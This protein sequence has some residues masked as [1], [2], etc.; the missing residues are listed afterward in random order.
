[1]RNLH[2]I[3][4][5][6]IATICLIT[7]VRVSQSV[8]PPHNDEN[9]VTCASC[10][11]SAG[12]LG[13]SNTKFTNDNL[14][15]SCHVAAGA[16]TGKK[17]AT[18][19][20]S[21]IDNRT[22]TS[23]RWDG[24]MPATDSPNNAYGLRSKASLA[25]NETS[26]KLQD[27]ITKFGGTVS[28]S[29][30]HSIHEQFGDPW[31]DDSAPVSFSTG[32][33]TTTLT[34]TAQNWTVNQFVGSYLVFNAKFPFANKGLYRQIVS[35]TSNTLTVSPAFPTAVATNALYFITKN[36][37]FLR[38]GN[39]YKNWGKGVYSLCDD[40]HYYRTEN[41]GQT[42][43]RTWTGNKLSHPI[44]ITLTVGSTYNAAPLEPAAAGWTQQSG[45][46]FNQNGAGDNNTTNNMIFDLNNKIRC[47]TCHNVHYVDSDASTVDGPN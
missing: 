32:G 42:N 25:L 39:N 20:Q 40:C 11:T 34:D 30:C 3:L 38:V 33:T 45:T 8:E 5:L 29:T 47:L 22:G 7:F 27:A 24:V 26:W 36:R 12:A 14:C 15:I 35:N 21:N 10:H 46:R 13:P 23:H 2:N 41:S 44:G 28:C 1:M 4:I 16:A 31:R 18:S 43:V 6:G 17:F 37:G 19:D 9:G